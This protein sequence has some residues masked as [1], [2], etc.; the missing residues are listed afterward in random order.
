LEV[1]WANAA[2]TP[3]RE[4][5]TWVHEGGISTPAIAHWPAGL[6]RPGRIETTPCHLIDVLPTLLELAGV[7]YPAFHANVPTPRLPGRSFA[8]VFR[9]QPIPIHAGLF[10]EHEGNRAYRV[11]DWKLVAAH[12]GPWELYDLRNDRCELTNLASKYP[13]RVQAL[14]AAWTLQAARVGVVDWELF[15]QSRSKTTPDYRRK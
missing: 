12:A 3:F 14:A 2:N 5:K 6:A 7:G 9:G 11:G 10:W 1:G 8:N 15:L 13:E 4:H